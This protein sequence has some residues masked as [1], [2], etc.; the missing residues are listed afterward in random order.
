MYTVKVEGREVVVYSLDAA[1]KEFGEK[2]DR[3]SL[4]PYVPYIVEYVAIGAEVYSVY[5][6]GR[7]SFVM[8]CENEDHA[9]KKASSLSEK[10]KLTA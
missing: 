10:I 6:N 9:I 2:F 1:I 3:D 4:K 7:E 8:L 5:D